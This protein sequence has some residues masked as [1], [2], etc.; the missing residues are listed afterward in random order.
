MGKNFFSTMSPQTRMGGARQP[1]P[2]NGEKFFVNGESAADDD[3]KKKLNRSFQENPF[4]AK[5]GIGIGCKFFDEFR[6]RHG[7]ESGMH[8]RVGL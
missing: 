6:Y 8:H 3:G 7:D 4:G 1:L 5:F 2:L